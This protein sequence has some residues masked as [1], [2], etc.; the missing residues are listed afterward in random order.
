MIFDKESFLK[1]EDTSE[2]DWT[3]FCLLEQFCSFFHKTQINVIHYIRLG[4]L[5]NVK[6]VRIFMGSPA[7]LVQFFV[8]NTKGWYYFCC[9]RWT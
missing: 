5:W 8:S 2:Q 4:K 3:D 7:K 9:N 6:F 1:T